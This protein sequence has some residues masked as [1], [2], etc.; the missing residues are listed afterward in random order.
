M[1]GLMA[2]GLGLVAHEAAA[3]QVMT[4]R[5]CLAIVEDN[6]VA[7]FSSAFLWHQGGG[8]A[9]A[10]HCMA[11]ALIGQGEYAQAAQLLEDAARAVGKQ[12]GAASQ[13]TQLLSQAGN[14][15]LMDENGAQAYELFNEALQR[16]GMANGIRAELWVDRARANA[17]LQDF[18]AALE[19]LNAAVSLVGLR[20][21]I[22]VFR[23]SAYR[24]LENVDRAQEDIERALQLRPNNPEAL[25]ERGNLKFALGD[26][27]EAHADWQK[28]VDVAPNSV[29]AQLAKR[30]LSEIDDAL[31]RAEATET[32]PKTR[33]DLAPAQQTPVE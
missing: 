8:G 19:D 26:V 31:M 28:V 16:R 17:A 9:S 21:D 1:T 22:L 11:L 3:S 25:H 29:T 12:A 5:S 7:G 14:A 30:N 6:P 20:S 24:M 13:M 32:I 18:S 2:I 27:A 23:A 4:Y 15:W 10:Q 33:P